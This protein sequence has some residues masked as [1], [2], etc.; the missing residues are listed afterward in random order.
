MILSKLYIYN[1]KLSV[2]M[3]GSKSSLIIKSALRAESEHFGPLNIKV[4]A[5]KL[6]FFGKNIQNPLLEFQT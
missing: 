1:E 5:H 3:Y 6:L 4:L 2:Q